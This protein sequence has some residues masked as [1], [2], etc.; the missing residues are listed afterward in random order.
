MAIALA[1]VVALFAGVSD[2]LGGL[3][4]RSTT[5]VAVSV[6]AH[7]CG[8]VLT[9][10]LALVI[11]G[12]PTSADLWWGTAAGIGSAIG[13]TAIYTGYAK[14]T[15]AIVAPVA[16][17]GSVSVPLLWAALDGDHLSS[18]AWV[19]VG[20]GVFAIFL[21]SLS[22]GATQGSAL[23][24]LG[25]GLIG[26]TGLGLVLLAFSKSSEGSGIWI[27]APSR[28]SG[29]V[30]LLVALRLKN[31]PF[32]VPRNVLP[33]VVLVAALSSSANGAYAVATREGSLATVAVIASMFPAITVLMA[34]LVLKERIRSIQ[35]TGIVVAMLA[36]GLIAAS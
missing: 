4:T 13:L 9:V 2:F 31:V 27:V 30:V 16:G 5:A 6:V 33:K 18:Q 21:V 15:V 8:F 14:S 22:H 19:G 3:S 7:A 26:A 12:S 17:V 23:T 25:Y 36:V 35:L 10:A 28:L 20:L 32:T 29:L 34:W 24:A 11:G 1:L